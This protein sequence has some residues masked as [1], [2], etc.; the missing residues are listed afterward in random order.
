[1]ADLDIL[2]CEQLPNPVKFDASLAVTLRHTLLPIEG[3]Y[4]K[5]IMTNKDIVYGV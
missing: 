1:M 5:T 4:K 3:S 2:L